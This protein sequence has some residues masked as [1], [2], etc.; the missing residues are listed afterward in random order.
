MSEIIRRIIKSPTAP[1]AGGPYSQGVQV[2]RTLYVSGNIG[3]DPQTG[4]FAGSNVTD[5]ARQALKNIGEI[6]KAAGCSYKNVVKT[7]VFLQDMNDFSA[8]NEVYQEV[9][10][11]RHPARS[12]IQVAALP[13]SAKVEIEVVAIVGDIKEE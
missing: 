6:L 10:S 8:M 11:D 13:K 1:P 3:V 9:F 7:T 4:N 5:Q 12:T 2:D